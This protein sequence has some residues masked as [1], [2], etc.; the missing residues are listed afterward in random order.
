MPIIQILLLFVLVGGLSL[1]VL[2]NLSPVLP[3][4]FLGMKTQAL[5]VAT[6]ILGALTAGFFTSL[7]LQFFS[8]LQRRSLL[9]RIR[10]LEASPSPAAG[11]RRETEPTAS[12]HYTPPPPETPI[13]D[14]TSEEWDSDWEVEEAPEDD[15]W[16]FEEEPK[17]P[18]RQDTVIQESREYEVKQE[19]KSRTV[20]GSVYSYNYREPSSSG[21]GRTEAV[22]DAN[23]RVITP[24]YRDSDNPTRDTSN[25]EKEDDWGFDDD[26]L[27]E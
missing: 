15:D 9:V 27:D 18:S 2:Q 1:L 23:Y 7:C 21:A 11:K 22:Y 5:P 3:I 12:R 10:Q 8:Y 13:S 16:E 17:P 14:D 26:E 20:T 19:P 24:P 25:Q 4:V 6:W